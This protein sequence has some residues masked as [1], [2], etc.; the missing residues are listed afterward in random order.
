MILSMAMTLPLLHPEDL[1]GGLQLIQDAAES[2]RES[3]P[4]LVTFLEYLATWVNHL[5]QFSVH[6]VNDPMNGKVEQATRGTI[7]RLAGAT[8]TSAYVLF[9][10]KTY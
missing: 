6:G 4:E 8:G 7:K 1:K 5:N 9:G 2:R 10:I 3:N